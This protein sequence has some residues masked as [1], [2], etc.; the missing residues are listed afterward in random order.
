M[1]AQLRASLLALVLL[2]GSLQTRARP[3]KTRVSDLRQA[4]R[5]LC[6]APVL[7]VKL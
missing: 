3:E 2:A 4:E 1:T 7:L 5:L 6:P